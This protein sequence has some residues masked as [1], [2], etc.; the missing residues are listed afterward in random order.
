MLLLLIGFCFGFFGSMPVAGPISVLVLHLGMA[1]DARHGFYVAVGGALAESLYSLLAFWG[2][3]TVLEAYPMVLPAS[4]AL[5]AVILLALG[6]V[7][8]LR[9][10][11]PEAAEAAADAPAPKGGSKRSFLMGFFITALNPTLMVTWTAAVA[12]LHATGLLAMGPGKAVPFAAAACAGILTWF[13]ILL[14]VVKK[15]RNRW[16]PSA[17]ARFMRVMGGFLV[18]LGGWMAVR[19]LMQ[20]VRGN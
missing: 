16:S 15:F 8:L 4:R 7:L 17:L 18:A 1:N 11:K 9:K 14:W 19:T 13:A 12:A 3:S 10:A 6:L 5:G 20:L 2:L